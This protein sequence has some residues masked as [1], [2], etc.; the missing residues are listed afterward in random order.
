M[1][2]SNNIAMSDSDVTAAFAT[3]EEDPGLDSSLD[4]EKS[5][6]APKN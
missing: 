2:C 5:L 3:L 6:S 4:I 1:F